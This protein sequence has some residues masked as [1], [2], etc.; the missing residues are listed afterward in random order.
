MAFTW[1]EKLRIGIPEID[2]EYA[3]YFKDKGITNCRDAHA[4]ASANDL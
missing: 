4:C 1:T 2:L 3:Q